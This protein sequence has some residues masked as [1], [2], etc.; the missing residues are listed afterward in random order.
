MR[1]LILL[2]M[3]AMIA[4]VG[5]VSTATAKPSACVTIQAGSLKYSA[6]HYLAGQPLTTGYDDWGY[7]YQAHQFSGSYANAYLGGAGFP[8]YDGDDAAYLAANPT[9]ANHWTWPYRDV[10]LVMKWNDA[11]LSNKDCDGDGKL[12]RHYGY[13]TYIGSGAWETNHMWGVDSGEHWS[14]FTKIVAVPADANK[15]DVDPT[16]GEDFWWFSAS[17]TEIGP[18]IWG[19]F[20]VVQEIYNDTG[21]GDHGVFYKSPAGPGFGHFD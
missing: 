7:N 19:E 16:L 1:K 6:A 9:A 3:V 17:D 15:V 12:D 21:T 8:A 10:Q 13:P 4:T 14:Y 5:A 2:A 11:W 20:A 18:D